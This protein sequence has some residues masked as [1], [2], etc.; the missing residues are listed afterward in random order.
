MSRQKSRQI[1]R[2]FMAIKRS[3]NCFI[4]GRNVALGLE[5]IKEAEQTELRFK[6][7]KPTS[8]NIKLSV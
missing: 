8:G 3:L 2:F 7:P 6:L 1:E 4:V 5:D